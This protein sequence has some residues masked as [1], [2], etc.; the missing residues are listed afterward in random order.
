MADIFRK[1]YVLLSLMIIVG[2][3]SKEERVHMQS[4]MSQMKRQNQEFIPFTSDSLGKKLVSYYDRF[5]D[6][7][8][9]MLAHYLLGSVYRDLGDTPM[10]L[11]SYQYALRKAD[12]ARHYDLNDTLLCRI[13]EQMADLY[14]NEYL[15][16][17]CIREILIAER[18]AW[19]IKDTLSAIID[20]EWLSKAYQQK[21]MRDSALIIQKKCINL[22]N[23]Y[24]Y[25][26][27]AHL[28]KPLLIR[29]LVEK[30]DL[31]EA[32][33]YMK[34]YDSS[35]SSQNSTLYNYVKGLY[36]IKI[37]TY[38][39]AAYYLRRTS[40][41]CLND[42]LTISYGLHKLFMHTQQ[43][44]SAIKYADMHI[45]LLRKTFDESST[46]NMQKMEAIYNY[47]RQQKI[48]DN[49]TIEAEQYKFYLITTLFLFVIFIGC[50][51]FWTIQSMTLRK[52]KMESIKSEYQNSIKQLQQE[53]TEI[54]ALT[55]S[56]Y[57]QVINKK[58]QIIM[59]L[60]EKINR[61]VKDN[62]YLLDQ[63][64]MSSDIYWHF[65]NFANGKLKENINC[66][67]WKEL[68]AMMD[69]EVPNLYKTIN[70]PGHAISVYEYDF[71]ILVR[72][73]FTNSEIC[74]LCNMDS[75]H[76]SV[77]RKRLLT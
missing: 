39:S 53:Q 52:K 11:Q 1:K 19:K 22:Y 46:A 5:G 62:P 50:I 12:S 64:L 2:C 3:T 27:Q 20:Y 58:E 42:S 4:L 72:L 60:Q 76:V 47:S 49:K 73:H 28:I 57:S 38:D 14:Y 23:K 54:L 8:E 15:P 31:I 40:S 77:T 63:R 10:A 29:S 35:Q 25:H 66:E 17:N 68:R 51:I 43:A 41:R 48:A 69:K 7:S 67:D 55:S 13:H 6:V 26:K 45:N 44:D 61:I 9:Q 32:R 16:D 24:G 21:G 37:G 59:D 30:G 74:H 34:E 71:C 70:V 56:E 65:K 75:A 18:L 36:F 33:H